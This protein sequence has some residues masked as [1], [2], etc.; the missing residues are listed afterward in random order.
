MQ[1][2]AIAAG[3]AIGALL[4]S[5]IYLGFAEIGNPR[6]FHVPTLVANIAGS[7]IIGISY[8]ALVEHA[9]LPSIWRQFLVVGLLG[10]LTTFSTFSL[11][12]FRLIQEGEVAQALVYM[13]T[14][15]VGCLL[16]TA[17]GYVLANRLFS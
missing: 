8:Y 16:A 12:G 15:V 13:L 11:D 2:L 10:A 14:S 4:R 3:G 5:F 17:G 9:L 6:L 7:F 1:W